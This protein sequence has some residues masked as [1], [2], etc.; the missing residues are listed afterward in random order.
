[1]LNPRIRAALG[2]EA[3][4]RALRK[5]TGFQFRRDRSLHRYVAAN[6]AL[7]AELRADSQ[8]TPVLLVTDIGADID[9]TLALLVCFILCLSHCRRLSNPMPTLPHTCRLAGSLRL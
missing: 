3:A 1:M 5:S 9:D 6:D 4:S 2:G 8:R 7:E